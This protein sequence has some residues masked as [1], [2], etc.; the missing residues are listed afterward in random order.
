MVERNTPKF[1]AVTP[2]EYRVPPTRVEDM[3][4]PE[5]HAIGASPDRVRVLAR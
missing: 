5:R 3:Y 4:R 2:G 1:Q